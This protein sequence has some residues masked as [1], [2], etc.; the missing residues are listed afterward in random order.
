MF[1]ESLANAFAEESVR[2]WLRHHRRME[3]L[4]KYEARLIRRAEFYDRIDRTRA[5]L[6]KLYASGLPPETMRCR[7]AELF[8]DLRDRFRELRRRWGGRGLEGWL[9]RDINNADL[10][11]LATYHEHVPTFHKLLADCGGDLERFFRE[12]K[13]LKLD[14]AE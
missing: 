10:V 5:G 7:K 11:S 12:A 13:R 1:N 14:E 6:E 9:T 8:G 3:D 2:R 4:K